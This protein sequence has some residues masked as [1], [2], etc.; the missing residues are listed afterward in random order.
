M[1]GPERPRRRLHGPYLSQAKLPGP[2]GLLGIRRTVSGD[3]CDPIHGHSQDP[4]LRLV[5]VPAVVTRSRLRLARYQPWCP[6]AAG[7]PGRGAHLDPG[8]AAIGVGG[9]GHGHGLPGDQV[10]R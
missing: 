10:G 5:P 4:L 9:A 7:R 8:D 6:G 3:R 2:A 1:Q